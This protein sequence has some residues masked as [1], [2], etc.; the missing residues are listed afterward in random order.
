MFALRDAARRR[1][2]RLRGTGNG[3]G[4]FA[5]IYVLTITML[6][7]IGVAGVLVVTASNVLPAQ[8]GQDDVTALTAAQAGIEDYVADLNTHC[9]TFNGSACAFVNGTAI[10]GTV[11]GTDATGTETYR[12]QAVNPGSYLTDGFLRIKSTGHAGTASKTLVADLAGLPSILR[13]AYLSTY[14]T[15]AQNF[16]NAY[17]PARTIQITNDAQGGAVAAD[18]T[19]ANLSRGS[20]VQWSAP[21][22][23]AICNKFWYDDSSNA[24]SAQIGTQPANAG[25]GTIKANNPSQ[26]VATDWSQTSSSLTSSPIWMPCEVTFTSGMRF[27]GP[28]YSRD[29]VYLSYGTTPPDASDPTFHNYGPT[30]WVPANETLPPVSTGWGVNSNPSATPGQLWRPFLPLGG[31]PSTDS[32]GYAAGSTVQNTNYD[33]ELPNSVADALGSA[34]CV[35]QG[36]TR[37]KM[38]SDGVTATVISPLTPADHA[39]KAGE[40]ASCY[41]NTD[42]SVTG[43][44]AGGV[45]SARVTIGSTTIYVQN[46]GT[47]WTGATASAANPVFSLSTQAPP[48]T[49][50][51]PGTPTV[52][53][54]DSGY[55]PTVQVLGLPALQTTDGQWTF[56]WASYSALSALGGSCAGLIGGTLTA[57]SD[58]QFFNCQI[59]HGSY[60]DAYSY[61]KATVQAALAAHPSW[62]A[63]ASQ[64]Q[65]LVNSIVSVGN[66][67]DWANAVPDNNY[68]ASHRYVVSAVT[69]SGTTDGCTPTTTN[70]TQ[71]SPTP[72]ARPS[73]DPFL[74]TSSQGYVYPQT[75]HTITCLTAIVRLQ[76]GT[77]NSALNSNGK[78]NASNNNCGWGD[79]QNSAGHIGD[80]HAIKQFKVTATVDTPATSVHTTP[81]VVAFPN[82]QDA[83]QYATWDA[84]KTNAPGDLYVESGK[85]ANGN[86]INISSKLSLVADHDVILSGPLTTSH[87]SGTDS[88]TGE[89]TWTSGGAVSVAAGNNVRIYHPVGCA[90][91]TAANGYCPNDITGLYDPGTNSLTNTDGTFKPTHPAMQYCNLTTGSDHSNCSGVTETGT[92]TVSEID[93]VVFALGGS[94]L[95]DNF[96]RGMKMGPATVVGGIYQL[97]RGATGQEWELPPGATARANSGY[98]LQDTY[99]AMETAGLPYVPALKSGS[100]KRSWNIVSVSAGT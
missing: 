41:T 45:T 61:V 12:L 8:Q 99:L 89:S 60:P 27:T 95:T 67:S 17:Y 4:G 70:P 13:F 19:R 87:T 39:L 74:S 71:G 65:A 34:T 57:T 48:D 10:N 72:V 3:D 35:Y 46:L 53:A 66:S 11:P 37:L 51:V 47:G 28:V 26:P 30:F 68:N 75:R 76:V 84:G 85:D 49:N 16:V 78:C 54:P 20:S 93:A 96:N 1:M 40:P 56:Q 91:G 15:L 31:A 2:A 81:T 58:L 5:L 63:T 6:I 83:T 52:T 43:I 62:Y 25:R 90:E 80:D 100:S 55:T 38:N 29:A 18:A 86:P 24:G 36:P 69:D 73:S 50:W 77:K 82:S 98:K 32:T 21:S 7:T 97:H 88:V 14:E 79:G 9:T 22:G 64:F 44:T 92:G 23:T 33:L 42:P 94:L 59:P